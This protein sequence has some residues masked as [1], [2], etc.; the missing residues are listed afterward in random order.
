MITF[1]EKLNTLFDDYNKLI[2]RKN[3]PLEDGNGILTR[4]KYPMPILP[5]SGVMIW[6]LNPT[7]I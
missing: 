6:I 5:F 1:K 4:Y 7:L 3:V 2:I